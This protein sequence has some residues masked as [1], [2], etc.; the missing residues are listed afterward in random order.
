[1]NAERIERL[2][3]FVP[4]GGQGNTFL[5]IAKD[6]TIGELA[7]QQEGQAWEQQSAV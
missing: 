7:V 3:V 1:M 2:G 5:Q 4:A 6:E